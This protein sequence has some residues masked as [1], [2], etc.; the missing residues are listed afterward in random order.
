[1]TSSQDGERVRIMV[2]ENHQV[3]ADGLTELLNAHSDMVVVGGA[4]SLA[5]ASGCAAELKPE[6]V[7]CDFRLGD[8]TGIE[9]VA[10]IRKVSPAT[11]FIFLTR[12][13]GDTARLA[14]LE[15]GAS[16]FIHKSRGA[17]EVVEAVRVVAAG[18]SLF[19]PEA[20]ASLLKRDR[21]MKTERESITARE[22]QVLQL[23]AVGMSS[24][25]IA[26]KLGISYTTV[27][28]HLRSIDAKLNVH[29]KVEAV[30]KARELEIIE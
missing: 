13:D 16:G 11:R 22:R 21:A 25:A 8:G 29:S 28:A 14:A 30:L 1:M 3:V 10:A 27:R 20:V 9:V 17:E 6:I 5:E 19:T 26:G 12:E 18:G 4:H 15:S 23:L 24:R 2:V 7:L